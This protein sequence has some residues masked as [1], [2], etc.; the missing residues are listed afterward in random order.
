MSEI[1]AAKNRLIDELWLDLG[2]KGGKVL[3]P[4]LKKNKNMK[5]LT[6][7]NDENYNEI[8]KFVENRLTLKRF[9]Y[10][11]NHDRFKAI[12]LE[13]EGVASAV[14]GPARFEETIIT[15]T[16]E[17]IGK[18]PFD[19][20][21]LDFSSQDPELENGRL[22]KEILGLETAIKIQHENKQEKKGYILFFT[23]LINSRELSCETLIENCLNI[24]VHGWTETIRFEGNPSNITEH[25]KKAEIIES[26]LEQLASKYNF[27]IENEKLE[28][29]LNGEKSILSI[30]A[31]IIYR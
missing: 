8:N 21:N 13:T 16:D 24:K 9:I 11:W 25:S 6:L 22:E 4:R 30:G 15:L 20:L 31:I 26:I 7:T 1:N 28:I 14:L 29:G 19:I 10:A 23:T 5:M 2:V 17:V 27:Y 3:F 12:R 18:S